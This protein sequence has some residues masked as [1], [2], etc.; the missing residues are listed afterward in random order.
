MLRV[1]PTRSRKKMA[2]LFSRSRLVGSSGD[3]LVDWFF[4]QFV[5]V[6][7]TERVRI[8]R[9]KRLINPDDPHRRVIRG[10]MDP[11]A[12]R[13]GLRVHILI[14]SAKN[15]HRDRDAEVETL[16]H[17]LA[18]VILP[19]A[20]ERHV[21]SIENILTKRLT[22]EQRDCLKAFV[23]RHEVKRYPSLPATKPVAVA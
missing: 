7:R 18:H 19:K 1:M 17:E 11:D 3:P 13:S 20:S 14:N 15:T 4:R 9:K 12:D 10:L 6:L 2:Q 23:P 22:R 16:I 21:L 8:V 5:A